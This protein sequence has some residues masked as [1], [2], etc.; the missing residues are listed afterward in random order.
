LL[1]KTLIALN[2]T[3]T[4]TKEKQGAAAPRVEEGN[5][6]TYLIDRNKYLYLGGVRPR[7][8]KE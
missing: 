7:E 6:I 4:S 2:N 8:G 3:S 5:S 1:P